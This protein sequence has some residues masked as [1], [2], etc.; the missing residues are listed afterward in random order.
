MA[1]SHSELLQPE[2]GAP[3]VLQ[4]RYIILDEADM[5]LSMGFSDDVE[6]ILGA[7]PEQR[8]TLL[9]SATMPGWVRLLLPMTLHGTE[10]P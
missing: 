9:F 8:Q 3:H 2:S 7:V 10:A 1:S 6:I 5:M 4:T